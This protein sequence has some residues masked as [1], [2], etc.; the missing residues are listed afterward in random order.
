MNMQKIPLWIFFSLAFLFLPISTVFFPYLTIWPFAP[1][2]AIV[3][4]RISFLKALFLSA[5]CGLILDLYSSQFPF[6]SLALCHVVATLFLYTKKKH[7]FEDKPIPLSLYTAAISSALSFSL[8]FLVCLP[9][10]LISFSPALL[11]SDCI[12]MPVLDACYAFLWFACPLLLWN[13]IKKWIYN[14]QFSE[15]DS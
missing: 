12:F 1:F 10:K 11:L 7:F 13:F 5:F 14:K 15:G 6:G 9:K 3:F 2:L 8:I 4:H